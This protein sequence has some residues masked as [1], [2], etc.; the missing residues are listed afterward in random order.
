MCPASGNTNNSTFEGKKIKRLSGFRTVIQHQLKQIC[1]KP[2]TTTVLYKICTVE[3]VTETDISS[4][5][6]WGATF[7]LGGPQSYG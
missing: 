5:M 2:G 4:Y 6:E 3:Q 1:L 7:V